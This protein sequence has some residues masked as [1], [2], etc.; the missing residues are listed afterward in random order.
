[1]RRELLVGFLLVA[2]VALVYWPVHSYPFVLLDDQGYV[3]EN[4]MVRGG[5][6]GE[7]V[8]YACTG[9][10]VGNWHPLT[11]LSHMLDSQIYGTKDENAGGHHLTSLALHAANTLLLFIALRRMTGAVWRS[12]FAAA[13]FGLHPLHV[14]S[15]A[16]ISERKDVLSTF[17]FMLL[18]LAYHHYAQRRSVLRYLTVFVLL[19]LGLLCKPMLVTAPFVLLLL[20]YWPLGRMAVPGTGS[21]EQGAGSGELTEIEPEGDDAIEGDGAEG[22]SA[23]VEAEA[24]EENKGDPPEST[25]DDDPDATAE[26]DDKWTP[27]QLVLEKLPL[28][29]LVALA[30]W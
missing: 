25:T 1:M 20:D 5:L 13:L 29:V 16:W 2:A 12:G 28:F 24:D 14:E 11:M 19:L 30:P 7:G 4:P 6:T 15:V 27:Q 3:C 8:V 17:F 9:V 23:E 26:M 22:F 10:T 18:L 21:G